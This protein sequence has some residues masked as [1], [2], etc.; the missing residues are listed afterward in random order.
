MP[1]IIWPGKPDIEVGQLVN[2]A[3]HVSQEAAAHISPS[4]LGELYW[5]FGWTRVVLGMPLIGFLFGFIGARFNLRE[6]RTVTRLLVTVVTFHYLVQGI[7]G[8]IAVSYFV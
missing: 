2:N 8:T 5:I 4:H 3:F 7:E 6:G 1:R